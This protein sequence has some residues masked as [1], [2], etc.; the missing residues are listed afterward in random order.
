M[1]PDNQ[2]TAPAPTMS[3]IFVAARLAEMRRRDARRLREIADHLDALAS[4][5]ESSV[6]VIG[7]PPGEIDGE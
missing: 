2:T 3:E 5:I 6:G 1:M 7:I 4:D